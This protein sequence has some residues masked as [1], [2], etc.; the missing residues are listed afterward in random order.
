MLRDLIRLA[1]KRKAKLISSCFLSII[2]SGLSVI[3]FLLIYQLLLLLFSSNTNQENTWFLVA[4]L[5]FVY[6]IMYIVLIYAYD[7]SHRAAY[8]ILYDVRIELGQ[9]MT[10]LP[11]GYFN[12]KNTGET[13][14][15][16]NENVERLEFFLAHHLPE[17]ITTIFVPGFL[18]ALLFALDWWMAMASTSLIIIALVIILLNARKWQGMVDKFLTAQSRVNSTIVEYTQGIAAIKAFNQTAES[19]GKYRKNMAMWRNT[20]VKW[21][22]ETALPFTLYQAFITSPLVVIIPV[23]VWLYRHETLTLEMFLLFLLVGPIFGNLFMRI[24]QFLRYWL[25][26]KECMDR[27]NKLRYAK[28]LPDYEEG[29]SPSRFDITFRDVSFSYDGD[30]KNVLHGINF[31]VP[32]GTMCALVGPS[33]TGK[34]TIARLVPRFWDVKN[35]EILI[36]E[37]NI[38]DFPL[39]RLLS[40]ISLVFQ[41]IYL[42][43]DTILKNIRLGKPEATEEEVKA[44]ACAARCD[45]FIEK[46]PDGYN[47]LVGERGL[48]LSAGEKQ[49]ICIARALLKDAPIVILDEATAFIDPENEK[50]IQEAVNNL[51][52]DRTVLVIAHML[53]TITNVDQILVV[54]KGRIVERGKH[55]ELV[56]EGGLFSRMWEAHISALGWGIRS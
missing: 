41:E 7:L 6:T 1:G 34:T 17:T 5:P 25:E 8:E 16:M 42:F 56:K 18:A 54:E 12:E 35:G 32:Q 36:G 38:K 9:R 10:K 4:L 39:E 2:S 19:F 53:S 46:L 48:G 13:E 3:P 45:E 15:I 14:T 51:V 52:K 37:C 21:S 30:E 28:V 43:N 27:V 26:E 50:L 29:R 11:L 23:G 55:K 40:C 47:T 49:R 24:Y 33:G 44:A 22:K 31:H 20:L